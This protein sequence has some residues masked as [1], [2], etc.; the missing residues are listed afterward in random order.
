MPTIDALAPAVAATD[1]DAIPVSQAG[2]VR[3]L[4]RAQLL[5]GTQP[6]LALP[7]GTLLGRASS[8]IGGPEGIRLGAGLSLSDGTLS[9]PAPYSAVRLPPGRARLSTKP[10]PTGSGT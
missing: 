2:T 7:P 4:T 10:A 5:E 6:E 9:G 3:K 8:G 1:S